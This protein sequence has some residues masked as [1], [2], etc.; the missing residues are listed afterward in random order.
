M[1]DFLEKTVYK[2]STNNFF[3][4]MT[5]LPQITV[6]LNVRPPPQTTILKVIVHEM[7]DFDIRGT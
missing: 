2:F 5:Q 4:L 7:D 1:F 3:R 6:K